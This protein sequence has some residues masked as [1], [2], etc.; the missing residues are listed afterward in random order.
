M[1][2]HPTHF[3]D[4]ERKGLLYKYILAGKHGSLGHREVRHCRCR[5][6][7]GVNAPIG[8]VAMELVKGGDPHQ[9]TRSSRRHWSG[10]QPRT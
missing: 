5:Q 4:F 1:P 9:P 8:L 6:G 3:S 2:A 10:T 7:D